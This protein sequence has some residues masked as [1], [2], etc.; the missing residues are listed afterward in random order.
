MSCPQ[1]SCPNQ[2]LRHKSAH[3]GHVLAQGYDKDLIIERVGAR[4][5][6]FCRHRG[7]GA[8]EKETETRRLPS[9]RAV[10]EA[11]TVLCGLRE[12]LTRSRV[13][14]TNYDVGTYL[15]SCSL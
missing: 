5:R 14:D 11:V 15:G 4:G 2:L 10:L 8:D 7:G 12:D 1:T 3:E 9:Y 13:C 6:F